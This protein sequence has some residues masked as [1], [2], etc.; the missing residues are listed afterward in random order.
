MNLRAP[1]AASFLRPA[2]A[3]AAL[4]LT[5]E[6]CAAKRAAAFNSGMAALVVLVGILGL[7]HD[8]WAPKARG[9]WSGIHAL[10]GTL[11]WASVIAQFYCRI[12]HSAPML[13]V[14]IAAFSRRLSRMVYLLLYVLLG[15]NQIICFAA[16][17]WSGR[18]SGRG[19]HLPGYLGYG[20]IALVTI[21][22][23]AA[24]CPYSRASAGA[25]RRS[26]A[27]EH[28]DCLARG[29]R[30]RTAGLH[31]Y[32]S[33]YSDDVFDLCGKRAGPRIVLVGGK[34]RPGLDPHAHHV[35]AKRP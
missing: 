10:F 33:R 1:R 9:P 3:V 22:I 20:M 11:L 4:G 26:S 29:P 32:L 6:Y 2:R 23:L 12:K 18:A 27:V 7:L 16:F 15:V 5:P 13:P 17:M 14:D 30:Q 24:M 8:S 21:H 19:E 35:Q 28:V 31:P 34:F 25:R